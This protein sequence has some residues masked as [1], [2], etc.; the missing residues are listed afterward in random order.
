MKELRYCEGI[1]CLEGANLMRAAERFGVPLYVYSAKAI[2]DNFRRIRDAFAECAP[3]IAYSAKANTS[4]AILR[5]LAREGAGL[6]V[7]SGGELE[8]GLRAG[9]PA[10]R[11]VYSGVGKTEAEIARSIECGILRF[12]IESPAEAERIAATADRLG[13]TARAALRVNPD[14]DAHTHDYIT[15][16]KKE[17]KFGINYD[18]AADVF[19]RVARM[20][21]IAL[22]GV[23]AHIGSEILR[24]DPHIR[25][26]DRLEGL[27]GE[28]RRKGHAIES[29]NLGGG[30]GIGYGDDEE[31]LD[32]AALAGRLAPRLK[33]LCGEVV[34]EPGRSI[35]GDTGLLLTRVVYIKN[36][37]A[38]RFAIVDAGMND[39]ARPALYNAY[40]RIERVREAAG[41]PLETIDVV[42]PICESA[43]FLAKDRALPPLKQGDLLAVLDA[44]AYGMAMASHYNS[45]PLAA[46]VLVSGGQ[47]HLIR[48]RETIEDL[49][50]MERMPDFLR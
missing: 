29:V 46:E 47:C 33:S 8:R 1:L 44:G 34:F 15:T 2:R 48:E 27:I 10:A 13:K 20:K 3:L 50:R 36:G 7:V 17:N 4:G 31:P 6:D 28:L 11:I 39:L 25:A 43:D 38:R 21:G 37:S 32:V 16:G 40:H 12:N 41:E 14:V 42:G 18:Q 35:V 23:H 30:F 9:F 24:I 5:L 45:R 49:M 19:D 26:L 22:D